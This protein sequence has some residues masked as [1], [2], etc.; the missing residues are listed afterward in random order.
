VVYRLTHHTRISDTDLCIVAER[1]ESG[2]SPYPRGM[3]D[4][5]YAFI[6]PRLPER[7]ILKVSQMKRLE[8]SSTRP[9]GS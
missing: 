6:S 9:H 1:G 2:A 8:R 3:Q 5:R 4:L 7:T